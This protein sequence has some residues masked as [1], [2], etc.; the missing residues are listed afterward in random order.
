VHPLDQKR[1][2]TLN[3]DEKATEHYRVEDIY[4]IQ[5]GVAQASK[6]AGSDQQKRRPCGQAHMV[7]QKYKMLNE[8]I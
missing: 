6:I 3:F 5:R 1:H 7:L 2:A 4:A 8:G